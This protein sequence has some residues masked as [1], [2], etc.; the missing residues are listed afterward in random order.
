MP[1]L[2]PLFTRYFGDSR[3]ENSSGGYIHSYAQQ[4]SRTGNTA[5]DQHSGVRTRVS[6]TTNE[7]MSRAGRAVDHETRNSSEIELK[8]I[9][10]QTTIKRESMVGSTEGMSNEEDSRSSTSVTAVTVAK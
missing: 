2:Q 5:Y 8:G 7:Y 9:Q 3:A 6:G 10:V 4:Q 1:Q